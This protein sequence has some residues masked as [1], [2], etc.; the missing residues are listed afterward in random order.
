[1][2]L[3]PFVALSLLIFATSCDDKNQTSDGYTILPSGIEYKITKEGQGKDLA[4]VGSNITAHVK[5]ILADSVL[6]DTKAMMSGQAMPAKIEEPKFVGDYNE[7][8]ALMK[9]GDQVSIRVSSDSVFRVDKFRPKFSKPGDIINYEVELVSLRLPEEINKTSGHIRDYQEKEIAAYIKSK[10]IQ[11]EKS[12][13]GFYFTI[14]KEGNEEEKIKDGDVVSINYKAEFLDGIVLD[15]NTDSKF[16]PPQV[17][18]FKIGAR[19]N[20]KGLDAG[21]KLLSK[22]GKASLILPSPLAFGEQTYPGNKANPRGLPANSVL[23]YDV[24]VLDVQKEDPVPVN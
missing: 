14:E 9:E 11:A 8:L 7:V 20:L 18:E 12:E 23:K 17:S 1:M 22:G 6:V 4:V 19:A 13:E 5:T 24:E 3:F 21:L 15:C 10:N 16:G 2:K